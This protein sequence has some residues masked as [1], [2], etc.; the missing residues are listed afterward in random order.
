[1]DI[2]A[3]PAERD[4]PTTGPSADEGEEERSRSARASAGA[5]RSALRSRA[6]WDHCSGALRALR[7]GSGPS[8]PP[9]A[10]VAAV[11]VLCVA[12]VLL[13][14]RFVMQPFAIPSGS[15][16]PGLRPGE[17]VL[18]NK[19]AYRFGANPQ[20][21]DV[22]VFDGT[23]Y[24]GGGDYV[25]RVVGVGGDHVVC[26][27]SQGRIDVNGDPVD[28]HGYLYPGDAPSRV[29]F[30]LT[31]PKGTLFLLGDH[32]SVSRD[33]RDL[34]GAPG[35]GMVPVDAVIG[36][37]EWVAWPMGRWRT[38][39]QGSAAGDGRPRGGRAADGYTESAGHAQPRRPPARPP[40]GGTHG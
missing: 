6:L 10:G 29:P 7:P 26:C 27:D 34:L 12:V 15:M 17:R 40:V 5:V 4:R 16:E 24:F 31:V 8:R 35:G 20:R 38:V 39:G 23:G 19:L 33:S 28:E 14:S 36:Q 9:G 13:V 2:Q 25:K 3:Q 18:V 32:R 1:M 22:V 21:G 11:L 37:A 30:D